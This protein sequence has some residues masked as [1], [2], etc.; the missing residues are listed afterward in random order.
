MLVAIRNL[1][2]ERDNCTVNVVVAAT[3]F[4]VAQKYDFLCRRFQERIVYES[5]ATAC[6]IIVVV[7]VRM[8][9]NYA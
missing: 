4:L 2:V 8:A 7:A 1:R 3:V 6:I 9:P 5:W